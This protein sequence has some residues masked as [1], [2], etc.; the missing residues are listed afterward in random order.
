MSVIEK[1]VE[2]IEIVEVKEEEKCFDPSF[3]LGEV[4][5]GVATVLTPTCS[6]DCG[7]G[8]PD[9]SGAFAWAY[10]DT[11]R[12]TGK[13]REGAVHWKTKAGDVLFKLEL[14]SDKKEIVMD[15]LRGKKWEKEE[16]YQ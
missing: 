7:C 14:K 12:L 4:C 16:K 13:A 11:W 8:V 3:G 10:K 2:I 6:P 5:Q 9:C 1:K 15:S